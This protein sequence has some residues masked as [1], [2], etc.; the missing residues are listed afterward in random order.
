MRRV[1]K[2]IPQ[3]CQANS[4]SK[5]GCSLTLSG[6]GR[7]R[8]I[9]DMDCKQLELNEHCSRCDYVFVGYHREADWVAPVEL[10]RGS[11]EASEVITQV[12]AGATFAERNLLCSG[13]NVRF[14][15]IVGHGKIH[16]S[17]TLELKKKRYWVKFQ[18]KSYEIMLIR[19]G[20]PLADALK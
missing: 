11:V 14:R 1:S 9:V 13:A 5:K 3:E 6:I 12:Q 7:T 18:N 20:K 16:R 17:Q 2:K 10:K 19:K 4:C 15:P 8:V